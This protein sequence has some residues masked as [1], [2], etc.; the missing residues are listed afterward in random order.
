MPVLWLSGWCGLV[1]VVKGVCG[2]GAGML[3]SRLKPARRKSVKRQRANVYGGVVQT[4]V[5]V[6]V[7]SVVVL[8]GWCSNCTEHESP[9]KLT[10][11]AAVA[12]QEHS[13]FTFSL[14]IARSREIVSVVVRTASLTSNVLGL[15]RSGCCKNS[16]VQMA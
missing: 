5:C 16:E 10:V 4:V 8:V 1:N 12:K 14:A 13:V 9:S 11:P 3:A 15:C 2:M 6:G 7:W